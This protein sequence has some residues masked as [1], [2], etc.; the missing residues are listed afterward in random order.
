MATTSRKPIAVAVIVG[1]LCCPVVAM[2]ETRPGYGGTITGSL[3][4]EPVTIDPVTAQSHADI[5]LVALIFDSLYRIAGKNADG[6]LAVIP[7][8]AAAEPE[9]SRNGLAARIALR[10][11]VTFHDGKKLGADDVVRSLRRMRKSRVG[12]L[13]APIRAVRQQG[14]DIAIELSRPTPELSALLASPSTGITPRGRAPTWRRAVGSGPFQLKG[15]DRAGKRVSL[16]VVN[17]HFAGRSYVNRLQLQ[18]YE[19]RSDEPGAYEAGRLHLSLR[20]EVAYRGHTPKYKTSEAMGPATLLVFVGFGASAEHASITDSR[21][22]RRALSLAIERDG[23]RAVG[24]GERVVPTIH[25][26]AVAMDGRVTGA[27]ERRARLRDARVALSRAAQKVPAL[28]LPEAGRQSAFEL[29]LVIDE[30]RL[31]DREIAEKVVAALFRLGISSRIVGV[32]AQVFATRVQKGDCD[33]YIG[34]LPAPLPVGDLTLAA[35]FAA[36]GDDWSKRKL[37]VD[38]L[39]L[40]K[41]ARAFTQR[42]PILPLFHRALRV[43]HRSNIFGIHFDETSR[44][45]LG[46]L[47]FFGRKL[48]SR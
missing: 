38:A 42:L 7:H 26:V 37:A 11:G 4:S 27:A 28:K 14:A 46:D 36:G 21:D 12:W 45:A 33:L 44:L 32:S 43:H 30:S 16:A 41:A 34:Q 17:R 24:T 22:F 2:G 23:F 1:A 18:W 10:P 47:Y 15:I 25:P 6:S 8:L 29:E 19:R 35:A 9:W 48:R 40:D 20:G 13:L 3:L 39:D 5:T 31:D